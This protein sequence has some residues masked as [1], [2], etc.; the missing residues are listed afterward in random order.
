MNNCQPRSL[1][2]I[3]RQVACVDPRLNG[4][5]L[6]S[7]LPEA[8]VRDFKTGFVI[9]VSL[10]RSLETTL[11]PDLTFE[12][13]RKSRLTSVTWR[14]M[15]NDMNSASDL[16]DALGRLICRRTPVTPSEFSA[17]GTAERSSCQ[18]LSWLISK[19]QRLILQMVQPAPRTIGREIILR[20]RL[21]QPHAMV[22]AAPA[23]WW[24]SD[25]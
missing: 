22:A 23:L 16:F 11:T 5:A 10:N 4:A 24:M 21:R 17:Y 1:E 12:F 3:A 13:G 9:T 20:H 14:D 7:R 6:I 19:H 15:R 18:S 25:A 2:A 8:L